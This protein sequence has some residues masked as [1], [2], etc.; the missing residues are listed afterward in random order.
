MG[1]VRAMLGD[2]T[3]VEQDTFDPSKITSFF[4]KVITQL[5]RDDWG[6]QKVS[7][8]NNEDVR[9]IFAKFEKR[10][11]N[12]LLSGHISIQFHVLLYY[13]PIQRVI[14]CQK[15]LSEVIE[16]T[17]DG[18]EGMAKMADQFIIKRLK[19][20]GYYNDKDEKD[21]AA[22]HQDLFEALYKNEDASKEIAKEI[23]DMSDV[24]FVK[25][26]EKKSSLFNELDSL[27]IETY[28]TTPILIDDTRLI[29][30]EEGSIC[31][32]DLEFIKNRNKE[33]LFDPRKI[34]DKI[35][36]QIIKDMEYVKQ[37]IIKNKNLDAN[38]N[39][40]KNNTQ[41]QHI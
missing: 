21:I 20:L 36:M 9:R 7:V 16:Q 30:G 13:R 29:G 41:S 28:H 14:D 38:L 12:Y 32:F 19:E 2:S 37:S 35:K 23:A 8:T 11:G 18:R 1:K 24:D 22:S 31:T 5:E 27:L 25:L 40:L 6:I 4:D 39:K 10:E 3:I 15:E 17:K 26:E 33:G 34:P